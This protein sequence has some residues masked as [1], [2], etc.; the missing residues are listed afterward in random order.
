MNKSFLKRVE[1][2][3][4][5][6]EDR[7]EVLSYFEGLGYNRKKILTSLSDLRRHRGLKIAYKTNMNTA[8]FK[9]EPVNKKIVLFDI[10]TTPLKGWVWSKWNND[11]Y[12]GQI[13]Q[14]WF[15]LGWAAKQLNS[16]VI[17]SQI[18][19]PEEVL[20]EDDERII[21]QLH[22]YLSDVDVV[23]AHN[24]RKFDCKRLNTRFI[25]HNLLPLDFKIIDTLDVARKHF[26]FTSNRLDDLAKFF[27]FEGKN[28]TDFELWAN[29]MEGDVNALEEMRVYNVQDVKVLE[30][31]YK[32]LRPYIKH[33]PNVS[34]ISNIGGCPSCN[35]TDVE[36]YGYYYTHTC[37]YLRYR[38]N[39]CGS[40]SRG[41]LNDNSKEKMKNLLVSI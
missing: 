4:N 35:S 34:N 22:K 14:E 6:N 33:H 11:L 9:K 19:Y 27:K 20:N 8:V 36:R 25:Y 1:E 15:I 37:K 3:Y 17:E 21:K 38:C 29:C 24:A 40:L 26:S 32:K 13:I 16:D 28:K 5:I 7:E 10:E 30:K 41:R 23:V 2:L 39:D 31:I 18:L 12:D